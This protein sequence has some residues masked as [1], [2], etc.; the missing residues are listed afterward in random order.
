MGM[1]FDGR[2]KTE[3]WQNGVVLNELRYHTTL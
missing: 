3:T 2:A 1:T